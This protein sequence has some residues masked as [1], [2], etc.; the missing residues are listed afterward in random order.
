MHGDLHTSKT[1]KKK[2]RKHVFFGLL[3]FLTIAIVGGIVTLHT[4][5]FKLYVFSRIDNLLQ[6]N[7]NLSIS[8]GSFNF[9]VFRLTASFEDLK[10]I[11]LAPEDSILQSCSARKLT[12]NL[13]SA[14]L[15]GKRIHIQKFHVTEPEVQLS[16]KKKIPSSTNEFKPPRKK[17]FSLRIDD[18]QLDD[19]K[20]D[21]QD[22]EYPITAL[23]DDISI[24]IHFQEDNKFHK[25]ILTARS[26]EFKV[27]ESL[28]S[29]EKFLTELTFDDDSI[30]ITRFLCET[31]PFVVSASGHIQDYQVN[32][33]Y[34]FAI[35][36]TLQ[37]DFLNKVSKNGHDFGGILSVTTSINGTGSDLTLDGHV[38]GKDI[39]VADIPLKKLEGDFQGDQTRIALRNFEIEDSDGNLT[40]ELG[41]SLLE[42]EDSTVELQWTSLRLSALKQWMPDLAL[43]SSTRTSGYIS[44]K[45]RERK[46]DS[47]DAKGEM[48]LES[49]QKALSASS[50]RIDL[51]GNVSFQA[52]K[53]I[54]TFLPSSLS[55]NQTALTISGSLDPAKQF[56]LTFQ[57][58]SG[59]LEDAEQLLARM[60]RDLSFP[61]LTK[62]PLIH[63]NG[64]LLLEGEASGSF[65]QP[66]ATVRVAGR[67]I[68]LNTREVGNVGA[69][70]TYAERTINIISLS[71]GGEQS[72]ITMDGKIFIDP[73]EKSLL[74]SAQIRLK[75]SDMD[76]APFASLIQENYS[77]Q[78]FL[79][80][81]AVLSGKL[82][83]LSVQ[84]SGVLN[85]VV[86]NNEDFSSIT[87]RG[88]YLKQNLTLEEFGITKSEGVLEGSLGLDLI[89]QIFTIDLEGHAIDLSTFRTINKGEKRIQGLAQL[90]LKGNGTVENPVFSLELSM[91]NLGVQSVW[92][93]ALTLKAVSDGRIVDIRMET[94][95]GQTSVEAKLALEE[96]YLIQGQL[97][98]E[99]IDIWHTIR[100][101]LEPLP[102]PI[103]SQ[104]S[105]EADFVIPLRDWK[106]STLSLKLERSS[107]RYKDITILSQLPIVVKIQNH[108]LIIEEFSLKGPQ[109]EFSVSGR[110]PLTEERQGNINLNGSINL[111]ILEALLPGTEATGLLNIEGSL[112]GSLS[113]PV[114]N[115]S[116]EM[117]NGYL[118]SPS[119]SLNFRDISLKSEI[120]E[121][122]LYLDQLS[123]GVGRGTMSAT[124]K[125]YLASLFPGDLPDES[126]AGVPTNNE[127]IVSLSE[128]NLGNFTEIFSTELDIQLGGRV[129]GTVR[130]HGDFKSLSQLEMEGELTRLEFSLD[131]FK[132]SNE[133]KIL[134][135]MKEG[136]LHL[137]EFRLSGGQSFL[138][139][140]CELSLFPD[141]QIDARLSASLDSAVLSPFIEDAVLGGNISFDLH[142]QGALMSPEISGLG[143]ISDGFFQMEDPPILVTNF[144]GTLN[145]PDTETLL[146]SLEG[147]ANG[148][149]TNIQGK[150]VYRSFAIVSTRFEAKTV[151][152]Q[153]NYPEGFQAISDGTIILEKKE[154]GWF[155]GGDI[156]ITQ[157]FYNA[158]IYPGGQLINT[159]RTRRRAL[160]SDIPPRIRS[161]NLDIELSTID[162]LIIENNLAD[163]E[164]DADI[165]VNGT[166]FDP[167]LSGFIR[168]RQTGQ[169][170]FGNHEYEVE[171]AGLDFQDADPLEGQLSVTAHTDVRSSLPQGNYQDIKVTLT[172]SGT[173]TNLEFGLKS[174]PPPT[175][176]EIELASLL[177]TG[178]GTER[179]RNDAAGVIGD[180]LML[181]FLSPFA[182]SFT[183]RVKNFLRAEEVSIEPINIAS[184]EDP[185]ARFTFRKGLIHALD[186]IYSIDIGDT[187]KQTWIL[188]YNFNKNFSLQS[189]AKDNGSYG[190]SF[191]HR[192]F[193]GSPR[194]GERVLA[195]QQYKQLIIRDIRLEGDLI[196][197]ESDLNRMS[198]SLKRGSVFRYRELR[199]TINTLE[200]FYK[201]NDFIN[202]VIKPLL[203]H[204]SNDSISIS[205]NISSNSPA[206]IA[207]KGDSL[208]K[209]LKREVIDKWDGRLP[210]A[211]SVSLAKKQIL[212]DLSS[213]GYLDAAVKD[214]MRIENG[215][216]V[217]V[218]SISF[219]PRYKIREFAIVGDSPISPKAIKTAVSSIPKAKGKGLWT[220]LSDF[221]RAKLRIE[222]FFAEFG[223]QN[224]KIS[225]PQIHFDRI[226]N[227]VDITLPI[228]QGIQNRISKIQINGNSAYTEFDLRNTMSIKE[229]AV[230]T[231]TSL[232]T[233]TNMLYSYYRSR[234]YQDVKIDVQTLSE[235]DE[236]AIDLLFTIQ[237]G[238]IHTITSIE[239]SGNQRT[240]EHI[241]RRELTFREGGIL[242]TEDLITSQKKLY[243][244]MIFR[245]VSI[246]RRDIG[247]QRKGA[248][249]LVEVQEESRFSAGYGLRYNSEEKLEG[250]AQLDL[251]NIIGRGR[252]GMFFY[253]QNDR[254]KDFR[255]SLKDPYLF[256]K[257][258]NTL[259][260]F[261][262]TEETVSNFKEDLWGVSIQQQLKTT[263]YSYL[264]YLF[265]INNTHSYELET[266][267]PFPFDLTYF[268]PEFQIFWVRDTRA[269]I[270]NAKQG[271]FLSLSLTYSPE[272]LKT[273]LKYISF[274]GQYS[275]YVPIS[276]RV[277]WASNYRIG[278]ADAFDQVLAP[279]SRRFFAGGA[280]S[281]RGF[282]RDTVGPY[283]PYLSVP[284]GG[285]ALFVV[286][287]E[288][289][290]PLYKWLE[291][292]AF[293]DVGN[294]YENLGDF[295]PLDVRTGA[296]FGLRLNLPAIF[297][298]LDYGIN[299]APR[300]FEK[301]TV[302]YFSIGQAF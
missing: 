22:R 33:Q 83:D 54:L 173:L 143:K 66:K 59:D 267:G 126:L 245:T 231:P 262:Y 118:A 199:K 78:G 284:I 264:S 259:Y 191:S 131:E 144:N 67:N 23:I 124:G 279:S 219:G 263:L 292:V 180:Q 286:N 184:E 203:Q 110:L 102:S 63:L 230:F 81:E 294:V 104:M 94:P 256:G 164:L 206:A 140:E 196:F 82:T 253:R 84:F 98:T 69:E 135:G 273:T 80:G 12:V 210:A 287:Q 274:F 43:L 87:M 158:D 218:F 217:Y 281:I 160:R 105:A 89:A 79:S 185:G 47:I 99:S 205:L 11:P 134:F 7:A 112:S 13:S 194:R 166:V 115:A 97:K 121:N 61:G 280:N 278:L 130:F 154:T 36:G 4:T 17:P 58:K 301:K 55:F 254:Q 3:I 114:L 19:G 56:N 208:N 8:A 142:L 285:E 289:R 175:L 93:G 127:I 169:I 45:W 276:S 71:I 125:I 64:Q 137:T 215:R 167:R 41:L 182:S 157:S 257:R 107:F 24:N 72:G 272:F 235:P 90:Q 65:E 268:L 138:Q 291:G 270:L 277:V 201:A 237:E 227:T 85:D 108:E 260:S 251:I 34:L 149:S 172:I 111:R 48:R 68:V 282:E 193:F 2:W 163:L 183:N 88:Q 258:F 161:L 120:K 211:M 70:L 133:E 266:V 271:S 177:I 299:L 155:L 248:K 113:E 249:I 86:V 220:L 156:K 187:Q 139:A 26:G 57:L 186:L 18:F 159:L 192:L 236:A 91:E 77:I 181:Y 9:N 229:G 25:G 198:R 240:P 46:L 136:L 145:F 174:S 44:A 40:G 28:F 100:S 222:A 15:F 234:G 106:N 189:Y 204:E 188:G 242:R 209:R 1:R 243:E 233:D 202:T 269:S 147:I 226:R 302:I 165:R 14:T 178:Y 116:M 128:L 224:V 31:A 53:G 32:P 232:A 212:R 239:V 6:T 296:G 62:L 221:K 195:P 38:R 39:L 21:Y 60:K 123:I 295:N 246:R 153:L 73:F 152:V 228:E 171:Q 214:S 288:L 141:A 244:L 132:I 225:P 168:S 300:E 122:V 151:G 170:V 146:L 35:Q 101:G 92:M 176:S 241:I 30:Q 148:G 200:A 51:K 76:I 119:I 162:A 216:S 49:L 290:F 250:I 10:I 52:Q 275:I 42:N 283:S 27:F 74:P 109:T 252:N 5:K 117:N 293:F 213:K 298:R 197:P 223:Y 265:R 29:L 247:D 95:L 75:A 261:Y 103:A 150:I 37:M 20:I 255:F 129:D 96:P 179:L 297:L 207:F 238:E 190:A 16:M 50:D